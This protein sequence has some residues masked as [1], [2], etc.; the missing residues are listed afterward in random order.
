MI[1]QISEGAKCVSSQIS[2]FTI[3][4]FIALHRVASRRVASRRVAS[5]RV[6]SRCVAL[7]CVAL[8]CV[9]LR[10]VALRCIAYLFFPCSII[11]YT[12]STVFKKILFLIPP[13]LV[14]LMHSSDNLFQSFTTIWKS[15][16]FRMSNME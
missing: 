3:C 9:A 8:R 10:C 5:R 14:A 2:V 6:A 7:R 15:A 13:T 1:I 12:P 16:Y 4:V 11:M